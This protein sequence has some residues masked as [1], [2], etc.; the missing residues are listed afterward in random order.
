MIIE[1]KAQQAFDVE[2]LESFK[3]DRDQVKKGL[4]ACRMC[5]SMGLHRVDTNP[6]TQFWMCSTALCLHGVLS[7]RSTVATRCSLR[8]DEVYDPKDL[9]AWGKNNDRYMCG[10]ELIA[11]HRQR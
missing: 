1:A 2:Q 9:D 10:E 8:A 3:T 11:A 4:P 6:P 7:Q 5:G